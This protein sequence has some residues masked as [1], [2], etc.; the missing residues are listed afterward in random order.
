[1]NG[2]R[3]IVI[4]NNVAYRV[5]GRSHVIEVAFG[6]RTCD[7]DVEAC[8]SRLALGG[9]GTATVAADEPIP[10]RNVSI[11]DNVVLNP[12]EAPSRWQQFFVPLPR[13]PS[14]G[15]NIPSPARADDGLVIARNVI[16]NGSADHSLGF[17][18]EGLAAAIRAGN[19]INSLRPAV[20][21]PVRGDYRVVAAPG[22]PASVGPQGDIGPRAAP[23]T[24][25]FGGVPIE[26]TTP[27]TSVTLTF[28]RA[29]TG[30]SL[31]DFVL[32]RGTEF[33]SLAGMTITTTDNRTFTIAHIPGTNVAGPYVVRLKGRATGITDAFGLAPAP[34]IL[35]TWRMTS[36]VAA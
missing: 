6:S 36:T 7:G 5:G 15:T 33:L 12:D 30:V 4:A 13:V 16:W 26:T 8:R 1:M 17:E 25:A 31:D 35:A 18:Q 19:A 34:P 22:I 14:P 3:G 11:V 24:A 29:V 2:G 21:D 10:N 20:I 23:L 27:L 28:A 32:K 9:W